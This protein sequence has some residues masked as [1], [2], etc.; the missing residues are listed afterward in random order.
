MPLPVATTI[1]AEVG[2]AGVMASV[3]TATVATGH[4]ECSATP[5]R[6]QA[7]AG[8]APKAIFEHYST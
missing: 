8:E 4:A 1:A 3:E 7:T 2:V 5:P 6:I